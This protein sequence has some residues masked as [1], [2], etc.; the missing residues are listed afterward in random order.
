MVFPFLFETEY[1]D[2]KHLGSLPS[3]NPS[4]GLDLEVK[5]Y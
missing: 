1:N 2:A 5:G 3:L 4:D